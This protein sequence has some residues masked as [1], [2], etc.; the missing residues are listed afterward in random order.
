MKKLVSII[1][2]AAM[3]LSMATAV[4]AEE[5]AAVEPNGKKVTALFFSLEG[6]FFQ[7][8]D[9]LLKQELEAKGYAYESQSS[10]FD[11]IT[12]CEQIENAAI[13]G[14]DLIWTWAVSGEAIADTCK[15]VRED[16]GVKVYS[17]VQNPGEGNVDVFRGTD[18]TICGNS[19]VEMAM[20]WAD[21][22]G[23]EGEGAVKTL[24]YGNEDSTQ[25]KE[26]Y[27]AVKAKITEDKRFEVL[28]CVSL[29]ASTVA[30]QSTTENMFA[31]YPVINCVITPSGEMA[32]GV[33]AYT[34]S[35]SSPVAPTDVAVFGT[36]LNEEI[37]SYIKDGSLI[38]TI[39]NGGI[40]AENVK[41][42][43]QQID[44]LLQGKEV[45][46]FSPVD[47]GKVTIENVEQYG[48]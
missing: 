38:G 46:A 13:G 43:A 9:G 41:A 24:I 42:Q 34:H 48:Y 15:R 2:A 21:K 14:T 19:I 37:A 4:F 10:N 8:F 35:E 16:Y 40:P 1:L 12:M 11:P 6:E 28:E 30:A 23:I 7:M 26:R 25:Q 29:E 32:L 47:M 27:E 31:K 17:F 36:E 39:M 22:N 45:E 18:E 33:L 44:D 3:I 20:E 5:P